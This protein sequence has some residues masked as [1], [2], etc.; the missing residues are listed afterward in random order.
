MVSVSIFALWEVIRQV[1]TH[2]KT[3]RNSNSHTSPSTEADVQ[4]ICDYLMANTI[5]SYTPSR[6]NNEWATPSRDPMVTGA[7]YATTTPA[8]RNFR[9]DKRRAYFVSGTSSPELSSVEE[10]SDPCNFQEDPALDL[11][12]LSLDDEEFPAELDPE[13]VVSFVEEAV[14]AL[15]FY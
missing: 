6:L 4:I 11:G 9:P 3:P 7:V 13:Q 12:D 14:E 8:Y 2:F 1:Q 15:S 10:T 5:Q